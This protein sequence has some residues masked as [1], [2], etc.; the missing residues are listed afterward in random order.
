MRRFLQLLYPSLFSGACIGI[1]GASIT[2]FNAW[3][4]IEYQQFYYDYLF[5][6]Y[7]LKTTLLMSD[8]H[9]NLVRRAIIGNGQITYY[10]FL[11]LGAL[12]AGLTTYTL[13]SA[14]KRIKDAAEDIALE[15]QQP[16][17][18][19][20][21]TAR[22]A[23]VRLSVR[24]GSLVA[25]TIYTVLWFNLMLPYCTLLLEDGIDHITNGQLSGWLLCLLSFLVSIIGLHLHIIFLRLTLL[26]TRAFGSI[27]AD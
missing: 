24:A 5:G 2:G 26:R 8:Q 3:S 23:F 14:T 17:N 18:A 11:V 6:V 12:L 10:I 15:M 7:G 25:W 4:Y 20:R 21:Q 27:T 13:L 9:F 1:V 19:F 22:E 16:G